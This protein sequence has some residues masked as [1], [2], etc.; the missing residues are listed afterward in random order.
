MAFV[1]KA[2]IYVKAGQGGRGAK[3]FR[4]KKKGKPVY[5]DG[6]RGGKGGDVII[7]A[8][9]DVLR[10]S[11]FRLQRQFT[12]AHGG[13]GR[14][15]HKK[16]NNGKDVVIEVPCGTVIYENKT[17]FILR[18]LDKA[19]DSV[20]IAR[21]GQGGEGNSRSREACEGEAGEEKELTLELKLV[22][23]L[24]II[25]LPNAGKSTLLSRISSAKPKIAHFPFTTKVPILGVIKGEDIDFLAV[26]IP[27]LTLG[28]H[29][30]R[31]LGDRFLK[32]IQRAKLLIHLIDMGA[33]D[34]RDAFQDY[35]ILNKELELYGHNLI[36]K[37]QILVANK[38]DLPGADKRLGG[39]KAKISKEIFAISAL[40]GDGL[41]KLVSCIEERLKYEKESPW[42][43]QNSSSQDRHQHSYF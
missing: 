31:G 34:D 38:I 32:H 12:A 7:K 10:P 19:G 16:G 15:N 41:D 40:N 24:G 37:P 29:E 25:S 30:K 28:S 3:S 4:G 17:N 1:D 42:S 36:G 26:E 43:S 39:F 14:S 9:P 11:A 35:V 2:K 5:P 33:T 22:V 23:D 6:G 21:G 8:C 27:A 20:V 18:D 13:Q